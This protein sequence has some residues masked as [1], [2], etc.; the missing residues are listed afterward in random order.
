MRVEYFVDVGEIYKPEL[1]T[2]LRARVAG[3]Y[4]RRSIPDLRA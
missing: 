4:S 2:T 1:A 3:S